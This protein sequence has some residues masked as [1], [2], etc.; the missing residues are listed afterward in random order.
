MLGVLLCL[1]YQMCLGQSTSITSTGSDFKF[2]YLQNRILDGGGQMN[3][4]LSDIALSIY[5]NNTENS[6]IDVK[7][8]SNE[9]DG[10]VTFY[11]PSIT[12]TGPIYELSISANSMERIDIAVSQYTDITQAQL[13][14]NLEV[15]KKMIRVWSETIINSGLSDEHTALITVFAESSQARSRD[16]AMVLPVD[17]L[18]GHYFAFTGNRVYDPNNFPPKNSTETTYNYGGPCEVGIL[19]IENILITVNAPVEL[20]SYSTSPIPMLY[21]TTLANDESDNR[22]LHIFL[23]AGEA[24]QLQSDYYDLSGMEII[25]KKWIGADEG[26]EDI[27]ND[28]GKCA[29]FSGNMATNIVNGSTEEVGSFDHVYEQMYPINTWGCEYLAVNTIN[30]L[31]AS[32]ITPSTYQSHYS[33]PS[34]NDKK[35]LYKIMAAFDGT[36]ISLLEVGSASIS[37]SI[38]LD[39]GEYIYINETGAIDPN[40]TAISAISGYTYSSSNYF[41]HVQA[42]KPIS[43]AQFISSHGI[44]GDGFYQFQDPSMTLVSPLSQ[45]LDE[46][47]FSSL[48]W[49]GS[50]TISSFQVDHNTLEC[51]SSSTK[52][53]YL[54]IIADVNDI[55]DIEVNDNP[56]Y[57]T[58]FNTISSGSWLAVG[59]TDWR[60]TTVDISNSTTTPNFH[61]IQYSTSASSPK[62]FI[63]YVY[64]FNCR[65]SYSYAAGINAVQSGTNEL[66]ITECLESDNSSDYIDHADMNDALIA[67]GGNASSGNDYTWSLVSVPPGFTYTTIASI[68][69]DVNAASPNFL[70]DLNVIGEYVFECLIVN[71]E[72]GACDISYTTTIRVPSCCN[73]R[74]AKYETPSPEIV[75]FESWNDRIYIEDFTTVIVRDGAELNVNN[76]DVVLGRCASI[77]VEE[78]GI[79]RADNSV[80]R[81]CD[82]ASPWSGILFLSNAGT[83]SQDKSNFNE[84]TFKYAVKAIHIENGESVGIHNNLFYN[85]YTGIDIEGQPEEGET[86]S[87]YTKQISGNKF[88]LD[89]NV[90]NVGV[91]CAVD[92]GNAI[93]EYSH[94]GIKCSD[95]DIAEK[96]T[97]NEF[98]NTIEGEVTRKFVGIITSNASANIT[99]NSFS[100]MYHSL[101]VDNSES[102]ITGNHITVNDQGVFKAQ[103]DVRNSLVDTKIQSNELICWGSST[104]ELGIYLSDCDHASVVD[105]STKGFN[106]AIITVDGYN[107]TISQNNITDAVRFGIYADG[108][109]GT[110]S[111]PNGSLSISCNTIDLDRNKMDIASVGIGCYNLKHTSSI[112]SNCILDCMVSMFLSA[113]IDNQV[114]PIIANNFIYNYDWAGIYFKGI[115]NNNVSNISKVRANTFYSNS[116]AFDIVSNLSS[117]VY[118]E[119][120]F[121][122]N[123]LSSNITVSGTNDQKFSTAS[124]GAQIYRYGLPTST[125]T[126]PSTQD[127]SEDYDEAAFKCDGNYSSILSRF[128][129][130]PEGYDGE[131]AWLGFISSLTSEQ[132]ASAPESMS[133]GDVWVMFTYANQFNLSTKTKL[134]GDFVKTSTFPIDAKCRLLFNASILS[135]DMVEARRIIQSAPT[136]P[137]LERWKQI[138]NIE[139]SLIENNYCFDS[140]TLADKEVLQSLALVLDPIGSKA[141]NLLNMSSRT[142]DLKY[143]ST[144]S[145][146]KPTELNSQK[147]SSNN[148]VTYPNPSNDEVNIQL[149]FASGIRSFEVVDAF[150]KVMYNGNPNYV[151]G[152]IKLDLR[153][154]SSG[155]YFIVVTLENSESYNSKFIK[156]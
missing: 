10:V 2:V 120:S 139:L 52:T 118:V 108:Q 113:G 112:V 67:F 133:E 151:S 39:K 130:E 61:R 11:H 63:S 41:V 114:V 20:N 132:L 49:P 97:N 134:L 4:S 71:D 122:L 85:N 91:D 65:E 47:T 16:A 57:P 154:W 46:V 87:A 54:T 77:Q 59:S 6:S 102:D 123:Q 64:G 147:L 80:F 146:G 94:Y 100:E 21:K 124:C 98:D 82:P 142:S 86:R 76:A 126:S 109:M 149:A 7:F 104:N 88:I 128:A 96:I 9:I 15:Q 125:V 140:L 48:P 40:G 13:M 26:T 95:V 28:P 155:I 78:G 116:N 72:N 17:A 8:Q 45:R 119:N 12:N 32:S 83:S 148:I 51:G 14:N 29:V 5:V 84:C 50:S 103:I 70:V 35:D 89:N 106:I 1:T 62:G 23:R 138:S 105:N 99:Q 60:F 31:S 115:S 144:P 22:S 135:G 145:V 33:A 92:G 18:G 110:P 44:A 42:N 75:G 74:T 79:L 55:G 3:S 137:D 121:G 30:D 53:D 27:S 34:T 90:F 43:V 107:T 156:I 56:S 101:Q 58:V 131:A 19:A 117:I 152:N 127:I 111:T 68:I 25:A 69:D 24:V 141:T 153:G 81:A 150:G 93:E 66:Y 129:T 143:I 38:T 136:T 73:I 37:S 36:I